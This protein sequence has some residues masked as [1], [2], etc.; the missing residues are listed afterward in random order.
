MDSKIEEYF[1]T[2]DN[3]S[4]VMLA[5]YINTTTEE[6]LTNNIYKDARD[7]IYKIYKDKASNG[8]IK[9]KFILKHLWKEVI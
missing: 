3:Y 4:I 9:A 2:N 6:I 7:K 5:N 1:N 8:D